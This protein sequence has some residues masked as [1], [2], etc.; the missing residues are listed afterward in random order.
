ME[1]FAC[2][3]FVKTQLSVP[4][5]E[6]TTDQIQGMDIARVQVNCDVEQKVIW[7]RAQSQHHL[8]PQVYM[9]VWFDDS[10]D[11]VHAIPGETP[12]ILRSTD[13]QRIVQRF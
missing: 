6:M 12:N 11:Q 9:C 1:R 2:L 13:C 5:D 4:D 3:R 8:V 7:Q 10:V